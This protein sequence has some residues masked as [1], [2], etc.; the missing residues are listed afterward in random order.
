MNSFPESLFFLVPQIDVV[1]IVNST[2]SYVYK[3]RPCLYLCQSPMS[4][5]KVTHTHRFYCR[6]KTILMIL[7]VLCTVL[8]V[9]WNF[10]DALI[11][12]T[13][14]STSTSVTWIFKM[15]L[16]FLKIMQ[17]D[18]WSGYKVRTLAFKRIVTTNLSI[19]ISFRGAIYDIGNELVFSSLSR[20]S[21]TQ[22]IQLKSWQYLE[23]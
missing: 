9:P 13:S 21:N 22:Y 12:R 19:L 23:S 11:W 20:T 2:L 5:I 7:I 1:C 3:M 10:I 17:I 8:H 4:I 6:T 15:K 14:Q 16:K 18:W